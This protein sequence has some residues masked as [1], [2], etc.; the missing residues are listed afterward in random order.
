MIKR[1]ITKKMLTRRNSASELSETIEVP[2]I[3]LGMD[4]FYFFGADE[5][6]KSG[7]VFRLGFSAAALETWL[8]IRMENG[9]T[10]RLSPE[11]LSP[12]LSPS[13][14]QAP[15]F[16]HSDSGYRITFNG[17]LRVND[18]P[19]SVSLSLA[20]IPSTPVLDFSE[21]KDKSHLEAVISQHRWT[22]EFF[23]TLRSLQTQHI[24]QAGVL[25]GEIRY[26]GNS[27]PIRWRSVRDH[28]RGIRNWSGW[29]SHSWFTGVSESGKCFNLSLI[30]FNGLPVLR[31]GYFWDGEKAQAISFAPETPIRESGGTVQV[32]WG[33]YSGALKFET[34]SKWDFEMRAVY[35][36]E[37]GLGRFTWQGEDYT[38][39][40]ERGQK[41][42]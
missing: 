25:Q 17:K 9:D 21:L 26:G 1:W 36:I 28:S 20:F 3:P 2:N 7:G 13:T 27:F 32:S 6:G 29:E 42:D 12:T 18:V 23:N 19:E 8:A 22:K 39:I 33:A 15:L 24:E 37:E 41:T 40:L 30:H 16:Q 10:L 38:G 5:E 4:S 14:D 34:L 35:L 11:T 31:A